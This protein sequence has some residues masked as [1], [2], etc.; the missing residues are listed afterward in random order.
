MNSERGLG[1]RLQLRW[2]LYGLAAFGVVVAVSAPLQ[3][4]TEFGITDHQSAS[5]A[6]HVNVIQAAWKQAGLRTLAIAG[7]I[8]DLIFIG[9]Y[10]YGAFVAGRSAVVAGGNLKLLGLII[11]AFAVLFCVTDYLETSLQLVQMIQ[12]LGSDWMAQ[13]A[14]T[15]QPIKSL[16]FI[17]TIAG[18][19]LV[20]TLN[21]IWAHA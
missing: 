5:S 10:S 20:I 8:G 11:A 1:T 16:S 17:V 9:I 19:L 13:I 7:M 18:V 12:D 2:W 3:L 6:A 4:Y 14:S 15:A 21:K